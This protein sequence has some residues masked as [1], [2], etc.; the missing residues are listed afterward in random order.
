VTKEANE[1]PEAHPENIRRRDF[2]K[3]QGAG[4]IIGTALGAAG[5][6]TAAETQNRSAILN[7]AVAGNLE[8]EKLMAA[9]QKI[10][11]DG[12]P[13]EH[14]LMETLRFGGL[15][16][17]NL[18]EVV[19]IVSQLNAYGVKPLKVFPIGIPYPDG[20][21]VHTIL[22][23]QTLAIL[24]RIVVEVPRVSGIEIFPRGIPKPDQFITQIGIR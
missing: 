1:K 19:R 10:D 13:L 4:M 16:K 20:V 12:R 21:A 22:N 18:S 23:H 14:E 7:K 15:D 5:L 3:Y 6:A 9:A 17:E 8:Q 11:L 24:S 2:L